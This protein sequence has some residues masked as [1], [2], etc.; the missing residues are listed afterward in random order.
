MK[1]NRRNSQ[2][3][4]MGYAVTAILC[5][6]MAG[7]GVFMHGEAAAVS[8]EIPEGMYPIELDIGEGAEETGI[9][10][11]TM[12]S[13]AIILSTVRRMKKEGKIPPNYKIS[14][15][16][17][18]GTTAQ[19]DWLKPIWKKETGIEVEYITVPLY[20]LSVKLMSE[21]VAKSGV[22]DAMIYPGEYVADATES[23]LLADM[24]SWIKKHG[25][26]L[27]QWP[28]P[29]TGGTYYKQ[30]LYMGKPYQ[31]LWDGCIW[32]PFYRSDLLDDPKEQ[33]AFEKKY[34][35]PLP[36]WGADTWDQLYDM[37]EFF[38]RP[39]MVQTLPDG[40]TLKG[41]KGGWWFRTHEE[42][43]DV[44]LIK[45]VSRGGKYFNDDGSAAIA[46]PE[47]IAAL[48]ELKRETAFIPDVAVTGTWTEMYADFPAGKTFSAFSWTSLG[49][50][51]TM[52]AI[53]GRY[54]MG[55]VP[56]SIVN[57]KLRRVTM[58][59][60]TLSWGISNY[61]DNPELAF[62]FMAYMTSP[63]ISSIAISKTGYW[64]PV[65]EN[66][67]TYP[68]VLEIYGAKKVGVEQTQ[69]SLFNNRYTQTVA[70]PNLLI[71]RYEEYRESLAA[72]V[73]G[74]VT[75]T[76]KSAEEALQKSAKKWDEITD[77]VGR[78]R[79]I[80]R[81]NALKPLFPSLIRELHG[82]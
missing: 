41:L 71:E 60:G 16:V 79:L 5:L 76:I 64:D 62:L 52:G 50:F 58:R 32:T 69:Q 81:W 42:I 10:L 17:C 57:G 82:W 55:K 40:T 72:N 46:S 30:V 80:A 34:G 12:D 47:G 65:R 63:R 15:L 9:P 6:V 53:N 28:A 77:D 27:D 4:L 11:E 20:D 75:G 21:A 59:R 68:P 49:K 1:Q 22:Y 25:Y 19:I 18:E 24:S 51:A 39:D 54:K 26:N 61:G 29:F 45:M 73:H 36:Q 66:H 8:V 44:F 13:E 38:N 43:G 37:M 78:D 23:G 48:E 35:Y 3:N 2:R 74:Y 31:T 70:M 67:F 7:A 14:V 56:G 33:A